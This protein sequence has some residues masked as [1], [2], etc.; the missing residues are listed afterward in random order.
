MGGKR[1]NYTTSELRHDWLADRWV[2]V[3]PQRSERPEDYAHI[4]SILNDSTDCPFCCGNEYETP[5]TLASYSSDGVNVHQT[6][7]FA[8]CQ[9]N[10]RQ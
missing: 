4:V 6:G 2:I 8:L 10:S 1:D 9:T 3:A 7:K 5:G